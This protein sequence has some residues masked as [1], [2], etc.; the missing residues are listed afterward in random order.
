MI[1]ILNAQTPARNGQKLRFDEHEARGEVNLPSGWWF[2]PTGHDGRR[3]DVVSARQNAI[4]YLWQR[5]GRLSGLRMLFALPIGERHP[6]RPAF[7]L[8]KEPIKF[9]AETIEMSKGTNRA[10][11]LRLGGSPAELDDLVQKSQALLHRAKQ[12]IGKR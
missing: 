4:V 11:S 2:D 7:W 12:M 6:H 9:S 10:L 3:A 5:D 8:G 1:K